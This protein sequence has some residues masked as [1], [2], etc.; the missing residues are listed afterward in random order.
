MKTHGMVRHVGNV[1]KLGII[2]YKTRKEGA[3]WRIFEWLEHTDWFAL[4][5]YRV[6][7]RDFVKYPQTFG[8]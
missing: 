6:Q 5:Q 4:I 8:L 3:T 1:V 7:Q 2:V